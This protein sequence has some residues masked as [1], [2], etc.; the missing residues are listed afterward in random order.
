MIESYGI[1]S[2]YTVLSYRFVDCLIVSLCRFTL[3]ITLLHA[4]GYLRTH[5]DFFLDALRELQFSVVIVCIFRLV[6]ICVLCARYH[7]SLT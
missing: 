7:D 2:C 3:S 4:F 5:T 1:E 6:D